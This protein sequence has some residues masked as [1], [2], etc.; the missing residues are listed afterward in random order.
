MPAKFR[1][2]VNG[3]SHLISAIVALVGAIWL[4]V[5]GWGSAARVISLLVYG[6]SLVLLFS[7]SAAYHLYNG[8]EKTLLTLRKCDHC[9][10]YIL[11]AGSYTPL[12]INLLTGFWRWGLLGII[13]GLALV[14]IILK[15]FFIKIPRG[16]TAGIYIAM[17]WCGIL[18]AR[19][20][21]TRLPAGALMW[22]I[23]GGVVYTLGAIIY[24][25]KIFNFKPGVFG[26]HE[27]WHIFVILGAL[28]HFIMTAVYIA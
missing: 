7:A 23:I 25:T 20:L 16:V 15:L 9:A 28:A 13:W 21:F 1:E 22:L 5:A 27:L 4:L 10:I 17:G 3:L 18:G 14:G 6:I 12:C 19:E 8:N 26:F 11:I 2:P 24:S